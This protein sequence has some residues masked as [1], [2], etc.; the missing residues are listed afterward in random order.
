MDKAITLYDWDGQD[1]L[2]LDKVFAVSPEAKCKTF[3][4]IF[5]MPLRCKT[6]PQ[7]VLYACGFVTLRSNLI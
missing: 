6:S 7:L 5:S 3:A 2:Y 1:L 4:E